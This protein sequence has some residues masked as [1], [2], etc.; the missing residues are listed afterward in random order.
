MSSLSLKALTLAKLVRWRLGAYRFDLDYSPGLPNPKF[1]SARDAIRLVPDG[2]CLMATGMTGTMRPAILYKAVRDAFTRTGHPC[3][4]TVITAGGAGGRGRVE[5]TVEEL[6]LP[7]LTTRFISGHLETARSL[8][9]LGASGDCELGV[10]P[11]G[12]ITHLA[13]AQGRGEGSVLTD[14]GLGSFI[15]PRVGGGSQVVPGKGEQLVAPENGS[16]RYRMPM[17]TA[18]CVIGTAADAEGNVYMTDAP[19]WAETREAARAARRNG[20][21]V[22]VTVAR[23]V[24]RD[25]AAIFLRAD[26]VD[27]IVV[28]PK[29]EMSV[30]VPQTEGWRALTP[31]GDVDVEAATARVKA[32]NDLMKLD[33]P[34]GPVQ[35]ML[36]RQASALFTREVRPG[37]N[38]VVGYGL[39]QEVGRQIELGGLAKDLTFLLETG[40][41]G[42]VPAPGIF[43]GMAFNPERL[44][45]SAEMFH[46][47]ERHLDATILG[48][49]QVDSEGNVNVSKRAAGAKNYIGPGGFL[50][51]VAAARTIIFVGAFTAKGRLAI[52]DGSLR[53]VEPGIPKFVGKV[54]EVTFAAKVALKAGKK[55][56]YVTPVGAFR[57]TGRGLELFQI[58]PGVD[59]E[60]D[61]LAHSEARIFL[62]EDGTIAALDRAVMTGRDFRLRWG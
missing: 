21:V 16:L 36:A 11:Q 58:A 2:A 41:Y 44:M 24:P 62:P 7:G 52:E 48:T 38:C 12:T 25:D 61:V 56:F 8:L 34:R 57:L 37:A 18:A 4:L 53:V 60:R 1:M 35:R 30:T 14:V 26:E 13:E 15:D 5:G 51:L 49:L 23:V 55:V 22:I 10:L 6:G 32:L 50:N 45:T 9:A 28:S 42:G 17:V 31:G 20:G 3:G 39:P 29:N 19:I 43:F 27:A 47:C 46:Y 40:V 33:P 59:V 54:D